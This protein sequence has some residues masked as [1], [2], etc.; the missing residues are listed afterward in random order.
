M[1]DKSLAVRLS[2]KGAEEVRAALRQ[3]FGDGSAEVR[4]FE[5]AITPTTRALEG[6]RNAADSTRRPLQQIQTQIQ[7]LNSAF[8][9][10]KI[11]ATEYGRLLDQLN[12]KAANIQNGARTAAGGLGAITAA[13]GPLGIAISAAFVV[14]K[15]LDFGRA[16]VAASD[17]VTRL[18]GRFLALTGSATAGAAAVQQVFNITSKTGAAVEDTAQAFTQFFIAGQSIG[19]TQQESARLVETIQKLG[20]VGGASMQSMIAGSRQLAQGLAADRFAGD[21]FKSVMENM[22]LVA[23]ALADALGVSIGKLREMSEAGELT[24]ERVFGALSRKAGEADKLF[25][26]I[27]VTVDRAAGQA[28]AA[29]TQFSAQLDKSLGVSR[30]ISATLLAIANQLKSMSTERTAANIVSAA[31]RQLA[32]AEE[33]L[34]NNRSAYTPAQIQ[35]VERR[36]EGLKRLVA[37]HRGAAAA[38]QEA[39]S[40]V[41]V[42]EQTAAAAAKAEA[43]RTK[44]AKEQIEARKELTKVLSGLDPKYKAAATFS[45]AVME[46]DKALQAGNLTA[47]EHARYVGLAIKAYDEAVAKA[48]KVK[49]S[50]DRVGNAFKN[51][52]ASIVDS[53][54]ALAGL[55]ATGE[56]EFAALTQG[57]TRFTSS[58]V[59]ALTAARNLNEVVKQTQA[60][61]KS[62]QQLGA[63]ITGRQVDADAAAYLNASKILDQ[64]QGQIDKLSTAIRQR[65]TDTADGIAAQQLLNETE[66]Q[67]IDAGKQ[68]QE[69]LANVIRKRDD[70]TSKLAERVQAAQDQNAILKLEIAGTDDS[71]E[72]IAKLKA[73]RAVERL[74]VERRL[75]L[76]PVMARLANDEVKASRELTQ[77]YEDQ[78]AAINAH[79]DQLVSAEGERPFLERQRDL[80][81]EAADAFQQPFSEAARAIQSTLADTF[82]DIFRGG[83]RSFSDLGKSILDIF[84]KLAAQ[85]AALLVFRPVVGGV[86]SSLGAS[87]SFMRSLGIP[88]NATSAAG[89]SSLPSFGSGGMDLSRLFGSEFSTWYNTPWVTVGGG[90]P[91]LAGPMS[92]EFLSGASSAGPGMVAGNPSFTFGPSNV[93]PVVGAGLSIFNAIQNPNIGTILGAGATSAGAI[94]SMIPS[95]A[96]FGPWGMAAGAVLSLLGNTLFKQKPSNKGAEYSF[97]LD[98]D[99]TTQ[100][101]GTKHPDQMAFVRGF[102][103]PLQTL[104]TSA[105]SRFGVTRRADATIGANY[106]IKEGSSFFYDAG[107]RDGGIENRQVFSFDP[108]DEASIAAA[109]DKLMVAFLKDADW[110]GVGERLGAQAGADVATALEASGAETLNDLLSDVDFAAN[111]QSFVDLSAKDLDPVALAM[112]AVGN[113][114]KALATTLAGNVDTFRQKASELGLGSE[115]LEGGLTRADAATQGYILTMLGI[116]APLDGVAAATER[117]NNFI[118]DLVPILEAAG[119]SMERIGQITSTVFDNMVADAEAAANEMRRAMAAA[120]IGIQTAIN[121]AI[122]P[123]FQMSAVDLFA[124]QGLDTTLYGR[125]LGYVSA[126]AT[127]DQ[128]ALRMVGER[129]T[130]NLNPDGDATTNDGYLTE[131]QV[132]AILGYATS[133]YTRAVQPQSGGYEPANDNGSSVTSGGGGSSSSSN[134]G[135]RKAIQDEIN[136]RR[137]EQRA[138]EQSISVQERLRDSYLQLAERISKFRQ[139]LLVSDLSPLTPEQQLAEARRQYEATLTKA[140]AGDQDAIG[141]LEG[142]TRTF[143]E[144]SG[145]YW[146]SS[147]GQLDKSV[148]YQEDFK[149]VQA[150]MLLVEGKARDYQ[151]EAVARLTTLNGTLGTVKT[152]IDNLGTKLDGLSSGGGSSGGGGGG[153]GGGGSTPTA[154]PAGYYLNS[155]GQ[156]VAIKF[157]MESLGRGANET[158]GSFMKDFQSYT[159][160][161]TE[162]AAYAW[163]QEAHPSGL[164]GLSRL[165]Y[166][167]AARRAGFPMTMAFGSGTHSNWLNADTGG[168]RWRDFIDRLREYTTVVPGFFAYA[169]APA[170]Y[171]LGGVFEGGNVVPFP[172]KWQGVTNGPTLFDVGRMGEFGPEAVMP[173][174]T[175]NG[176]GYGVR[177]AGGGSDPAVAGLLIEVRDTLIAVRRELQEDKVQ[178]ASATR[179]IV[180][181]EQAVAAAVRKSRPVMID[182]GG[183]RRMTA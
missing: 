118:T 67:W 35:G 98:E 114:G 30:A 141:D 69:T 2:L 175:M 91:T 171:R 48:D 127:G 149:R 34:A 94:M 182:P 161:L 4:R 162:D 62:S 115:E 146:A 58:Q 17:S 28:A 152:A 46:L 111:F 132:N 138:I 121:T 27:P 85:I 110:S 82:E 88:P 143:L 183:G 129:L 113:E 36:I 49:T 42:S 29:W 170:N 77:V 87:D 43:A 41:W 156:Q 78:A 83:I 177:A 106:G 26:D 174:V 116:E 126:A 101:E 109:S 12:A 55:G 57:A 70:E 150:D 24:A 112:R 130:Y 178:R 117:A 173:L 79:Y 32:E 5:Q 40:A 52:L 153:G 74:E 176:G 39:A 76:G 134:D 44:E 131:A 168:G 158:I 167:A 151:A 3:A 179:A 9:A 73:Q 97:M 54:V 66:L 89:G 147:S 25:A 63:S 16:L 95:M 71:A 125:L 81:K 75:A 22:P 103:D 65:G 104:I 142:V 133:A 172:G 86:L 21:E 23:R 11:E 123:A 90:A 61:N 160:L 15:V 159:G 154:P 84:V 72:A 136:V 180:A 53:T 6:V 165:E 164:E 64:Y 37:A 137:D 157:G 56:R 140:I 33:D 100:F 1:A 51:Q 7:T 20:V 102:A 38:E 19:A 135:Q 163:M 148:R 124:T 108:E 119:F 60:L 50:V 166:F 144:K 99:W 8:A 145:K 92:A 10:G 120:T 80:A 128:A 13:L 139:S 107:P 18:E 122:N 181:A 45:E 59:T 68:V 169:G 105:E 31:A 155:A 93:L 96:G 47:E 14:D